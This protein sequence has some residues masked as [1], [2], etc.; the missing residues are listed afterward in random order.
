M[1]RALAAA[2]LLLAGTAMAQDSIKIAITY[3]DLPVHGVLPPGTSR[4]DVAKQLIDALKAG[5][6]PPVYGV[7]NGAGTVNEPASVAVLEMWRAAGNLLGNHT[8]SHPGLS[9]TEMAVYEADTL[10]N[11]PL[12]EKYVAG[13][14]WHWF[15]YPFID[16]GKDEAQRAEFR[17][18][19][20]SHG[21]KIA[22]VSTGL[23]DWD[24]PEPYARCVAKNDAAAIARL[25]E[26]FLQR[27]AEGL[28][29]S[30]K[31]SA[32]VYGR[33]IPYILLQHIGAFQAHILP[34][35]IAFY[36]E[37]GVTFITLPEA[38]SD[39]A[40][41]AYADPS[42]P[43]PPRGLERLVWDKGQQT[44]P[45]PNDRIPELQAMCR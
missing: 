38:T 13:T 24:Y 18:F 42:L 15:R 26:M 33:D 25:D 40:Y 1:I 45:I 5:G 29:Y 30:R 9:K 35:L 22:H 17:Q 27:A 41:A 11:E 19:L 3:D 44:P 6:V 32:A 20:A 39:P 12:L 8:W 36:K 23:N 28:E 31:L 37:K 43:N 7:I 4:M 34:K 14:D 10:K 21:Y 16:E 2:T